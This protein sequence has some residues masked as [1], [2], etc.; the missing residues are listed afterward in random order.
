MLI[1]LKTIFF[2][3]LDNSFIKNGVYSRIMI[4][5]ILAILLNNSST[6]ILLDW[7]SNSPD[8]NT[9][10]NISSIVKHKVEKRKAKN[11]DELDN[12]DS[13]RH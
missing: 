2:L 13:T 4:L 10:E 3:L 1:C 8:V 6:T 12:V 7:R 9:I 5:N 11:T